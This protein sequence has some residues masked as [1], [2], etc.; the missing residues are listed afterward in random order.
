MLVGVLSL[1][2]DF[3]THEVALRDIG[4]ETVQIRRAEDAGFADPSKPLKEAR[5]EAIKR[6]AA[7]RP[8]PDGL[9]LPGG[10]S[11]TIDLLGR[12]YGLDRVLAAYAAT[13]RTLLGTCAGAIWLGKGSH[14]KVTPLELIDV[15][16][17]R[18]AYGR[19]IDSFIAD[20]EIDGLDSPFEAVWIRAPR[21]TKLGPGVEVLAEYDGDPVLVRQNNIWLATFHPERSADRRLHQLIFQMS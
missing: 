21:I 18:N 1:Q 6:D 8:I 11:S 10:E 5:P 3:E 15:E 14:H 17:E 20:I 19:Q 4:I 7:S 12:R 2:G 9:V 16:L 13:G